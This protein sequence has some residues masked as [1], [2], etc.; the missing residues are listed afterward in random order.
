MRKMTVTKVNQSGV[1]AHTESIEDYQVCFLVVNG[2]ILFIF[3]WMLF[4]RS[5]V[6]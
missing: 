3:M 5:E 6:C 4:I 2:F 1:I